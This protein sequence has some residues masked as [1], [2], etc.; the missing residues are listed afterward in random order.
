MTLSAEALADVL[1]WQQN[2]RHSYSSLEPLQVAHTIY[3]EA[4]KL[5]WGATCIPMVFGLRLS[6]LILT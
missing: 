6:G 3:C 1:W 5:G 4:N 2:V